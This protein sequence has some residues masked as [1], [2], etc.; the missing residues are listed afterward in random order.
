MLKRKDLVHFWKDWDM[1]AYREQ[2]SSKL[3]AMVSLIL[4]HRQD[5]HAPPLFFGRDGKPTAAQ[6]GLSVLPATRP[7]KFIVFAMYHLPRLVIKKVLDLHG[8]GYREF[9]GDMTPALRNKSLRDF[10]DDEDVV[11]LLMSNVGGV[12]LNI[13][14]SSILI[15][16]DQPWSFSELKQII[17]R[18]WRRGQ[19]D[20]VIVYRLI[21]AG[22]A[23]ETLLGIANG[24]EL[25]SEHLI[26]D[27]NILES[28]L[29]RDET[30]AYSSK[31]KENDTD[32]EL[33]AKPHHK[34]K[35]SKVKARALKRGREST[36]STVAVDAPSDTPRV[37]SPQVATSSHQDANSDQQGS[38]SV[39]Q[40]P[41]KRSRNMHNTST[42]P[43]ASPTPSAKGSSSS[44]SQGSTSRSVTQALV[45][46]VLSSPSVSSLSKG[47]G[48]ADTDPLVPLGTA[49][50]PPS[51]GMRQ[52]SEDP[53]LEQLKGL[54]KAVPREQIA[55]NA[56]LV[57]ALDKAGLWN[58]AVQEAE[59]VSGMPALPPVTTM[60]EQ[61]ITPRIQAA[62]IL[63][64]AAPS[65]AP[66]LGSE[67]VSSAVMS[68]P[69]L[70][71]SPPDILSSPLDPSSPLLGAASTSC[72]DH[73]DEWADPHSPTAG[74]SNTASLFEPQAHGP[75]ALNPPLDIHEGE[76][77]ND[78]M[79]LEDDF[80]DLPSE[81]QLWKQLRQP[82]HP[83]RPRGRPPGLQRPYPSHT[84]HADLN[85]SSSSQI[86]GGSRQGHGPPKEPNVF[87]ERRDQLALLRS[88]GIKRR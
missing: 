51:A 67:I 65:R 54:L 79:E 28:I 82:S 72:M 83:S 42:G 9:D 10:N 30:I 29:G 48:R 3:R 17:G 12:G 18:P 39:R 69:S 88:M 4:H 21:A 43:P 61:N 63:P 62:C 52:V 13:T 78:M 55:C 1:A 22:T 25:M 73:A 56:T 20:Q 33:P 49:A 59:P 26:T 2:S 85:Q 70:P 71:S 80:S 45:P 53:I 14:R 75:V 87:P 32:E 47:K 77:G 35:A 36:G 86:G 76:G 15:F 68:S 46:P 23:D 37:L 34:A 44:A 8:L 74:S 81:D 66:P 60:G 38:N 58:A 31:G 40:P 50:M 57:A 41:A 24:K 84:T 27:G 64:D 11:I 6:E 16:M 19:P 5:Q 7:R